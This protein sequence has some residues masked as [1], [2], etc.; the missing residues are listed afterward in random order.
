MLQENNP[1][2]LLCAGW[3]SFQIERNDQALKYFTKAEELIPQEWDITYLIARCLLK[4]KEHTRAY[5]NLYKCLTN[6]PNN[7]IYWSS[8]GILFGELKEVIFFFIDNLF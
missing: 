6:D 2:S 5:D 3:L 1:K 7:H 8:L 4:K